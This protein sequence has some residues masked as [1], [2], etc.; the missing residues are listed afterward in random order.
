MIPRAK[1]AEGSIPLRNESPREIA[2]TQNASLIIVVIV[3][4]LVFG[5][6]LKITVTSSGRVNFGVQF[7]LLDLRRLNGY[8]KSVP[9]PFNISNRVRNFLQLTKVIDTLIEGLPQQNQVCF[10]LVM[11]VACVMGSERAVIESQ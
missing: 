3:G 6:I 2:S 7:D 9:F 1:L 4:S 5:E 8:I 11:Q 10:E